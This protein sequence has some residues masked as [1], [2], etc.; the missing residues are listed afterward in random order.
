MTDTLNDFNSATAFPSSGESSFDTDQDPDTYSPATVEDELQAEEEFSQEGEI[1]QQ[2]KPAKKP[3]GPR[4]NKAAVAKIL[5]RYEELSSTDAHT[6]DVLSYCLS[7]KADT[8]SLVTAIFVNSGAQSS[9]HADLQSLIE[10]HR[11]DPMSAMALAMGFSTN[12]RKQVW[13]IFERLGVVD[14]ALPAKDSSAVLLVAKAVDRLTEDDHRTLDS[15]G[16]LARR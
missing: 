14:E 8:T 6:I 7:T 15:V 16:K 13:G 9:A 10:E 1:K 3:A 12:Q 4:L 11:N 5:D 2:T